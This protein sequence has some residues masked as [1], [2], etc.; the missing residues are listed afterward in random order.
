MRLTAVMLFREILIE[1]S[2]SSQASSLKLEHS[3]V[4]K[5]LQTFIPAL[6]SLALQ[7]SS[8]NLHQSAGESENIRTTISALHTLCALCQKFQPSDL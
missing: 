1:A 7:K 5:Y 6:I 3:I 4:L 8:G 2:D